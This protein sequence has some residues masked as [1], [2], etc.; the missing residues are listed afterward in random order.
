MEKKS[1]KSME[2]RKSHAL[3][4]VQIDDNKAAYSQYTCDFP[5]NKQ[6]IS[7]DIDINYEASVLFE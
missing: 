7:C 5:T 2:K 3:I 4:S 1:I 6:K